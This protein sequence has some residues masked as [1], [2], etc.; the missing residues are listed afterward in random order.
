MRQAF[1]SKLYAK[2]NMNFLK[3][4]P[5]FETILITVILSIHLYA[6]FSDAYNFPNTWF[7][8]DDAYYYFKV[9]QN[10]TEGLGSTFDGINATNGY[11]PLWMIVCIPI[12]AL[13]RFDLILP[14]RIL[15]MVMAGFNAATSVMIYR[16][17]KR[18]LSHPV[19]IVAAT[20]WAFNNYIHSIVYEF[21]LETP[22]AAFTIILLIWKLSLFENEWRTKQVSKHQLTELAIVGLLVIF[23]RLDLIFLVV[24][25]GIWIVFRGKPIRFLLPL[26]MVVII[27]SMT[28]SVALR[29]GFEAYNKYY[30]ASA[31]EAAILSLATKI[32]CLYLFGAYQPPR[33]I[34][35]WKTIKQTVLALSTSTVIMTSIYVLLVQLGIGKNFPRSAFI[36]DWA[37]SLL[38][39][40]V[41]RLAAY[42]VGNKNSYVN[43]QLLTPIAELQT[44]WKRWLTDGSIY[45]GVVGG[46]LSIYMVLNKI[47]FGTSSPVSGQIKRWWGSITSTAYER[48]ASGWYSFLGISTEGTFSPWKPAS[49]LLFPIARILRPVYPGSDTVDERS[50]IAMFIFILLALILL[51]LNTRRV[52]FKVS[53]LALV[54]LVTGCAIQIFSYTNTAYAGAKEWYWVGEMILITLAGS[55]FLDLM[56]RPLLKVKII[57]LFLT[58]A[59]LTLGFF[60]VYSFNN[61]ILFIMPYNAYPNDL[62]YMEVLPFLEEKTPP[63]SI[64]GMTG[65]GNIGYF[66]QD[67]TIVNMDGLINSNDYFHALQNGEAPIY[68]RQRGLQIVFANSQLLSIPPYYGQ[69]DPYLANFSAY[70]GKGLFYLLEEPKY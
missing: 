12:F 49:D 54:P 64:I 41:I 57:R 44:N 34:S 26:D 39:V 9:A 14:L 25:S 24:I 29:T 38:F 50:Y 30:A 22:L 45:Y 33:L 60:F 42:W 20:F 3:R 67:R 2:Q 16:L 36:A 35:F 52:L 23:S 18:N 58:L 53:N 32:I 62:P 6:A 15:L 31:V 7:S 1:Y 47:I 68:L 13:A 4:F 19:A 37:I 40:I 66:I 8:R 46:A 56:I 70:G 28:S 21:G 69:F 48:P 63:G 11:H 27:I 55:F 61:Y 51:T 10:I 17:V 59:S 5:L 65:G 43:S